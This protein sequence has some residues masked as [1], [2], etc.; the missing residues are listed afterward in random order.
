MVK[1]FWVIEPGGV[2][3]GHLLSKAAV[4]KIWPVAHLSIADTNQVGQ[5]VSGDVCQV[6]GLG[7]V[8]K[9][10]AWTFFLVYDLMDFLR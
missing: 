1:E 6:N 5:A 9:D 10:E 4:A 8:R 7:A 2:V 3:H